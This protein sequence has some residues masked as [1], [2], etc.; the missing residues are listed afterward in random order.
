MSNRNFGHRAL[1][2]DAVLDRYRN[3]LP[4]AR[5]IHLSANALDDIVSQTIHQ[6]PLLTRGDATWLNDPSIQK[7][8][9]LNAF[10]YGPQK[11]LYGGLFALTHPV[12]SAHRAY[13]FGPKDNYPNHSI[14][15]A[16]VALNHDAVE[17][18]FTHRTH[19][20]DSLTLKLIMEC[21]RKNK[22]GA[23]SNPIDS[24]KVK[25]DII[26]LTDGRGLNRQEQLQQQIMRAQ[27]KDLPNSNYSARAMAIRYLEK[28]DT[29]EGDLAHRQE[30]V[31]ADAEDIWHFVGLAER[32]FS[33]IKTMSGPVNNEELDAFL[34]VIDQM[35]LLAHD[36][37]PSRGKAIMD[38]R[39]PRVRKLTA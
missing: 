10:I 6:C 36:R 28:L 32:N 20:T 8:I 9:I 29:L 18:A 38:R 30:A 4:Q 25:R 2:T 33:L 3:L 15:A 13:N 22:L 31:D 19:E 7:A 34:N 16:L 1:A 11:R 24:G 26:S 23:N 12:R 35:E 14:D 39:R 37:E 5:G 21:V 17:D 27:A